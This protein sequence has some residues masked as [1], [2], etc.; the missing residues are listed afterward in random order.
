[1][2]EQVMDVDPLLARD[3]VRPKHAVHQALEAVGL[4]DDDPGVLPQGLVRELLLE[5]LG[6]PPQ[7]PQGVL[8]LVGQT[9]DEGLGRLVLG[10][11]LLLPGDAQLAVDLMELNEQLTGCIEIHQREGGAVHRNGSTV[12]HDDIDLPLREG[13]PGDQRLSEAILHGVI[14]TGHEIGRAQAARDG[15]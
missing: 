2:L 3:A 9:A 4:V 14:G 10:D 8:D 12:A 15:H 11:Q 13:M 5:E 7:P 1:V 6:G